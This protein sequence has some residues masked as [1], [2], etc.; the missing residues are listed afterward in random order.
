MQPTASQ[1]LEIARAKANDERYWN[2]RKKVEELVFDPIR[3]GGRTEDEILAELGHIMEDHG[4]SD[5]TIDRLDGQ[6]ARQSQERRD[7][8]KAYLDKALVDPDN[9]F[10]FNAHPFP[11]SASMAVW[12]GPG[13][14]FFDANGNPILTD[15]IRDQD[16]AATLLNLC[17]GLGNF[18]KVPELPLGTKVS[19]EYDGFQGTVIGHY[20]RLDGYEGVV[21]QQH[22]TRV[23]HV[24]GVKRV[25]KILEWMPA[26]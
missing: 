13:V 18:M 5:G 10:N 24:Y 4:K 16:D 8:F 6:A 9:M 12:D 19:V 21:V 1:Q 20:Q 22:G 14:Q 26:E 2:F 7:R 25:D 15:L 11:W 17:N 23:V 3:R